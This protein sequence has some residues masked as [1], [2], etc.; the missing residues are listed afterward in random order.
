MTFFQ[1]FISNPLSLMDAA[2]R[3][4]AVILSTGA[5]RTYQWS[6]SKEKWRAT[7]IIINL[8]TSS[9][10]SGTMVVHPHHMMWFLSGL[11]LCRADLGN[12]SSCECIRAISMSFPEDSISQHISWFWLLHSFSHLLGNILWALVMVIMVVGGNEKILISMYHLHLL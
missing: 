7:Y 4:I 5:W 8:H 11:I 9:G 2:H 1:L 6:T 10:D 3:Q 12:H